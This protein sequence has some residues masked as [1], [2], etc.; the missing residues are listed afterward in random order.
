MAIEPALLGGG[1]SAPIVLDRRR[2][3]TCGHK[4]RREASVVDGRVLWFHYGTE[5][6][7]PK[8]DAA[9]CRC[10]DCQRWKPPPPR[11]GPVGGDPKVT[12]AA[13]AS[14]GYPQPDQRDHSGRP[15]AC[16]DR[17][18]LPCQGVAGSDGW[19]SSCRSHAN[20]APVEVF[21]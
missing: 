11:F 18:G 17:H 12:E 21:T 10:L 5:Q 6:V 20:P 9:L 15:C 16:V 19:C 14:I 8:G 1:V 4:F 2:C 13:L 7:G 3:D